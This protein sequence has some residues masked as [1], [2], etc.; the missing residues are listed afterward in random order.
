MTLISFTGQLKFV[1]LFEGDDTM[2]SPDN[3]NIFE[4]P[5]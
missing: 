4:N 1:Y 3:I 5:K 2:K